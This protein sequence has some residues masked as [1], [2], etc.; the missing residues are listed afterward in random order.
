[1]NSSQIAFILF[2]IEQRE[3]MT[4]DIGIEKYDVLGIHEMENGWF[5]EINHPTRHF[6]PAAQVDGFQLNKSVP[7]F[8]K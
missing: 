3:R 6:I 1:M 5:L 2:S 7:L 4:I 8:I